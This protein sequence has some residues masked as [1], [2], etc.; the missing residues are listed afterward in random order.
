M[1][2]KWIFLLLMLLSI[3]AVTAE[4]PAGFPELSVANVGGAIVGALSRVGKRKT[5]PG[6]VPHISQER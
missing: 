2:M 4:A 1:R 6:A 3:Q 5:Q